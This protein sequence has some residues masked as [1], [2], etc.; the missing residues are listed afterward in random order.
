MM[1]FHEYTSESEWDREEALEIGRADTASSWIA[2]SRDVWHPNPFYTGPPMPHPEDEEA[3]AAVL[4]GYW[5]ASQ[6]EARIASLWDH[7]EH[8]LA[9]PS[10]GDDD[11]PF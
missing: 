3:W 9:A 1:D 10:L 7:Y 5:H 2:T 4:G 6:Y 11:I 8:A